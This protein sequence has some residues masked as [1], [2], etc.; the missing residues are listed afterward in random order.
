MPP[1]VLGGVYKKPAMRQVSNQTQ[2]VV[3]FYI[4]WDRLWGQFVTRGHNEWQD[5]EAGNTSVMGGI[6]IYY[7]S[8]LTIWS[9]VDTL[10]R[11]NPFSGDIYLF[12][13]YSDAGTFISSGDILM[14]D[15]YLFRGH[16][17]AGTFISSLVFGWYILM[18]WY[19]SALDTVNRYLFSEDRQSHHNTRHNTPHFRGWVGLLD[20]LWNLLST[21]QTETWSRETIPLFSLYSKRFALE[22]TLINNCTCTFYH[23]TKVS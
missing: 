6:P 18:R 16:Y 13:G 10:M 2:I 9:S 7:K 14:W 5:D 22:G 23:G 17:D 11:G 12:R 3:L 15:I 4:E 8:D 19:R 1:Q 20:C 21:H